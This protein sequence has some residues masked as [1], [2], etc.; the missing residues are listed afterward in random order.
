MQS[1]TDRLATL[2]QRELS[3]ILR[4]EVKDN[5]GFIT[6]TGVKITNE[7]SYMFVY[8]TVLGSKEDQEKTKLAL[9]RANGFIRSQIASR[10]KMFKVPEL[11]F[12]VDESFENGMKVDAILRK[13][14]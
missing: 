10:V 3:D 11:V 9:E 1:K 5:L 14:K 2:V 8:Y 7:L 13:I 6:V 4:T 12:K